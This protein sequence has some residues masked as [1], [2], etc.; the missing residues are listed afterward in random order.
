VSATARE[1]WPHRR[2][3]ATRDREHLPL[4][5]GLELQNKTSFEGTMIDTKSAA[6]A[7]MHDATPL[8]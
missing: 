7:E 8:R 4:P 3:L 6:V 1:F 2:R 5:I